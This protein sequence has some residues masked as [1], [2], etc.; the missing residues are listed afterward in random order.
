MVFEDFSVGSQNRPIHFPFVSKSNIFTLM[1]KSHGISKCRTATKRNLPSGKLNY[2]P[3]TA[4]WPEG[5]SP[6][7]QQFRSSQLPLYYKTSENDNHQQRTL[8]EHL[9]PDKGIL[10]LLTLSLL[11]DSS[12]KGD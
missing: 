9:L 4:F 12:S 1:F 7:L 2:I 6:K 5:T 10:R 11:T 8:F 3:K